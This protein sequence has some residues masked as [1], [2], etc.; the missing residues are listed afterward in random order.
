M[1]W[2][3]LAALPWGT[4]LKEAGALLKQAN[5]LRTSSG[6]QPPAT[7]PSSD[8]H[9]LRQRVAELEQQQRADAEVMQRLATQSEAV[10]VAAQAT[11]VKVRQA[12]LLALAGIGVGVLAAI[13]A[14]LR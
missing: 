12:Y 10:A 4:I 11:A 8:I 9:A 3:T 1:G 13:L 2:L 7:P 14:L 5:E 6:R